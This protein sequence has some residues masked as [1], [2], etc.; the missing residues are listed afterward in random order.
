MARHGWGYSRFEHTSHGVAAE[1]LEYV[2]LAD[3]LK[4]SRLKLRNLSS[5]TR[6]LSVT[7]YV[8][9]VLGAS[10]GAAAPSVTTRIDPE[11]GAMLA[12]NPWNPAFGRRAAFADLAGRQ[13]SWTGDRREF[14]GRNGA[15]A[16]PAALVNGTSLTG[17]VGS[18]LDP[19]AALQTT[20]EIAPNGVAEIVF[21]LGD[22][23]DEAEA[24]SLIARYRQADLDAVLIG[25]PWVLG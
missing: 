11:S 25:G 24:Q 17:R 19:C 7:A 1:L 18:G 20:V 6:R 21:F 14:I 15:L 12:N 22:A 23:E 9:W 10:R 2:P 13:T 3:P 8:E 5:R 16:M 4:I